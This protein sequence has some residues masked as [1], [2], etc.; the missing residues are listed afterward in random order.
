VIGVNGLTRD[1]QAVLAHGLRE[2]V[3]QLLRHQSLTAKEVAT[4]LGS[5]VGNTHYH[6]QRL[7]QA[8]LIDVNEAMSSRGLSEKRY[9]AKVDV[10]PE[11]DVDHNSPNVLDLEETLWLSVAEAGQLVNEF[12]ALVYRWRTEHKDAHHRTQALTVSVR[13]WHVTTSSQNPS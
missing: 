1:Q 4:A 2:E 13:A 3:M 9:R 8:N 7:V 11:Q 6:L 5:T 10:K 12:Q